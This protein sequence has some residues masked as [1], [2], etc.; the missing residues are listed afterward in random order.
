MAREGRERGVSE[1]VSTENR[2][3][4]GKKG[5]RTWRFA[6]FTKASISEAEEERCRVVDGGGEGFRPISLMDSTLCV[7][8]IVV[9]CVIV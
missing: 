4:R 5:L 1:I 8:G 2:N 3:L 7:R 6:R 9:A